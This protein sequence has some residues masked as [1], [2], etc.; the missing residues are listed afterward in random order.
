MPEINHFAEPKALATRLRET[1]GV[2][3]G[4]AS[5]LA[6]GNRKPSLEKAVEIEAKLGIPVAAWL[7]RNAA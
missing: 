1:L 5:D 2:S 6:N 3:A 4:Y 7:E